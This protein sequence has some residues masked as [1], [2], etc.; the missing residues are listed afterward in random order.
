MF[1]Y[2]Q[3]KELI[4]IPTLNKLLLNSDDAVELLMFTCANESI[5]GT[6]LKQLNGPAL[7]VFQM[8]PNTYNDIWQNYITKDQSLA[9]KMLHNFNAPQMPDEERMIYDLSFACA[10]ARIFYKR[11][12]EALPK[13]SNYEAIWKYYKKYYNTYEGR[14]ETDNAITNYLQ[15]KHS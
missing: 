13:A 2:N 12:P 7:G 8:E 14:A 4:V 15:F 3:F 5:G 10:M 9:M 6:Y 1:N 11:I